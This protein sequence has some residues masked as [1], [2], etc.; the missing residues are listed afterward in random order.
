M[1]GGL[2]APYPGGQVVV[3][4]IFGHFGG[5]VG[6]SLNFDTFHNLRLFYHNTFV[7]NIALR[8]CKKSNL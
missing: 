8:K 1:G 7:K 5:V 4:G 6:S 3:G 2:A